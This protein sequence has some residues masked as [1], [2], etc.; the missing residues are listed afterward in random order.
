MKY[1]D[2]MFMRAWAWGLAASV[3]LLG[4]GAPVHAQVSSETSAD[5]LAPFTNQQVNWRPCAAST[6]CARVSVPL[7]YEDPAGQT[8]ELAIRTTVASGRQSPVSDAEFLFIN[9]G[10]PGAGAT[11]FVTYFASL[12]APEISARFNIIG[13]DPRGVGDSTPVECMT[14]VQTSTWLRTNPTPRTAAEQRSFMTAAA[15]I[16]PGCMRMSPTIAPYVG[17]EQAVRDFDVIRAALGQPKLNWFGYS[18]GT[19]LG[20]AYAELYPD[21]VGLMVLDGA[22]DP[23]LDAM[24]ISR[25]QSRGFQS[26]LRRY[27]QDCA[28]RKC[29]LGRT[30]A[31][32]LASV[33]HVLRTLEKRS[34][35]VSDGPKL[36]RA[37]A[38][39]AVF[40]GMYSPDLWDPLT[41]AL[42]RA[43]GGDGTALSQLAAAATDRTGPNSYSS[44]L[45]SAFFAI[46]CWD[47]PATPDHHGLADSARGW[48]RGA[49]VPALAEA[50]SWLNAPCSQWFGHSA[51]SPA[52]AQ[53]S[54]EAPIL[55][56][57]TQ[58]DPATP[59]T[60]AKALHASLPTSALLTFEGDGHTAYGAGSRC[61]DARVEQYLL[62]AALPAAGATCPNPRG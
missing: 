21:R 28:A 27:A 52:P 15:R 3:G 30:S 14:G 23:A 35:P 61:I 13:V 18:Y 2:G 40:F 37:E 8:I 4:A 25:D 17:T 19:Q 31:A 41:H 38:I 50:M 34:L 16:S 5:P 55:I 1:R 44:N 26:A 56:V 60:W 53:S 9:P 42:T 48:S 36:V 33:N 45:N 22:V 10:G 46:N 32:V 62:T 6:F 11:D 24:E 54:T 39:T 20:T 29:S 51:Q 7:N 49:V 58:F 43:R 47:L 59:Y 12:V 57:G